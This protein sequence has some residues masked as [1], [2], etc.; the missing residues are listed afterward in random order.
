[1]NVANATEWLKVP[2]NF[3]R[4]SVSATSLVRLFQ[5]ISPGSPKFAS[6]TSPKAATF[7]ATIR[8]DDRRHF[9]LVEFDQMGSRWFFER[10]VADAFSC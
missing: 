6:P 4:V 5:R 10:T 7:G 8:E 2:E 9:D 3:A 1:M